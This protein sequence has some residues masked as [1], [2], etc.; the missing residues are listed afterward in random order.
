MPLTTFPVQP[1]FRKNDT[2]YAS[3]GGYV[4]GDKVRF[5]DNYPESIGGWQAQTLAALVGVAREVM[6]WSLL[7]G[8]RMLAFGTSKKLYVVYH[9]ALTNVTPLDASGTLPNDPF[10]TTI[11]S[12]DVSVGHTTHGRIAGDTVVYD[13][14]TAVGGITIDGEYLVTSVTDPDNYV[15]THTSAATSSA[16]GGG[17][18]VTYEYEINIG[19]DSALVGFGWGA[20]LWGASTWGT[21]RS[22]SNIVLPLRT[23]SLEPWGEDLLCC[24]I[25]G[26]IYLWDA[27]NPLDRAAIVAAAPTQNLGISVSPEDR[28]LIA[29]GADGDLVNIKWCNQD[30]FTDWT[31]G[32]ASTAGE[33]RLLYG[34]KITAW[35]RTR[36][37]FLIW[38]DKGLTTL[39]YVGAGDFSFALRRIGDSPSPVGVNASVDNKGA[40]Y[41]MSVGNFYV[42]NGRVQEIPCTLERD[43]FED[44]NDVQVCKVFTG[45]NVKFREVWWFYPTESGSGENDR[46]VVYNYGENLWYDGTIERTTWL[47]KNIF[48]NPIATDASGVIYDHEFGANDDGAALDSFIKTGDVDVGDGEELMFFD[49]LIPDLILSGTGS[50]TVT[51]R[52]YPNGSTKSKTRTV[53]SSTEQVRPR[54]RGRQMSIQFGTNEI[55]AFWRMGKIRYGVRPSGGN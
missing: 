17:A 33:R 24:P 27:T 55:D 29:W 30:D 41:W 4:D 35:Q 34:S 40:V 8:S 50:F 49:R 48:S 13:G 52:K 18:A 23:W 36:S 44:F 7:D 9:G 5:R 51:S 16:T 54:L 25:G 28:H 39:Q 20:G 12:A 10:T 45:I 38:T 46:Y 1:G 32:P 42:Y 43:L 19:R 47:D 21:A 15:I 6:D 26:N 31:P 22:A 2:D 53:T 14:A 37:E 3:E 11:S